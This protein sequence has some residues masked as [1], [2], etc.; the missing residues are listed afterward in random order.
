[1][2]ERDAERIL[3]EAVRRRKTPGIQYV[4]VDRAST[5][6]EYHEGSAELE[7][8]RRM[9]PATSMMAYSMSKT[10]TAA[11]V[12]QFVESGAVG[13]DDPVARHL[14][15]RQPYGPDI[16]IRQLLTHTAGIPNPIPLRWVH[17]AERHDTFDE[18]EALG[19]VLR[20]YPRLRFPPGTRY[21]YSNV[22]YWL[23]GEIVEHAAGTS[24]TAY[25]S[26]CVL[27]RLDVP[28]DALGYAIGD[29]TTHAAG[30]LER[31]SLLGLISPWVIESALVGPATGRWVR[32]RDHYLNGPAFGGLVG[33]ARGLA[34]FLQD[35]LGPHSR[36]FGDAARNL[37][38]EP[39]LAARGPVPMTPGW[40]IGSSEHGR[41]FYKE[42]GGGGF[43]CM[44]RL[45]PAAGI[46]SVV[47]TNA[48]ACDVR[49]LLD[50]VDPQ[51]AR[52]A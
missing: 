37:F 45:Y 11:A 8:A 19:A 31:L 52:P 3:G 5:R 36:L 10:V 23:L 51:F 18:S 40:H 25:V 20:R 16:T 28:A 30:Y 41:F 27:R 26:D 13:L 15:D 32:I 46:G 7:S 22:G 33:T 17:A 1:M 34:A 24:F 29:R 2:P 39:Q 44:M 35:Q 9:T 43:H 47:M 12:L 21:A 42:G 4:V 50:Q 6:F 49:K 14:G 48:T 38:Y